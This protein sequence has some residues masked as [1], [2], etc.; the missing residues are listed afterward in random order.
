M[1]WHKFR[2]KAPNKRAM[3]GLQNEGDSLHTAIYAFIYGWKVTVLISCRN[4][5]TDWDADR[6]HRIEC[7]SIGMNHSLITLCRSKQ[8]HC[9][10]LVEL[11]DCAIYGNSNITFLSDT[12]NHC[13]GYVYFFGVHKA[14]VQYNGINMMCASLSRLVP[15]VRSRNTHKKCIHRI[16]RARL[17]E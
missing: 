10:L 15:L 8:P 11:F 12:V 16:H 9:I 13:F 5:D 14:N 6:P 1:E 3:N 4:V 7:F 17:Q 2:C